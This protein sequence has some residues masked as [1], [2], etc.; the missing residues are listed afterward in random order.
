MRAGEL[1]PA[2]EGGP[3]I[4]AT[5][6]FARWVLACAVRFWP[7]ESRAWGAALAAEIDEATNGFDAMRWS[8]GG[9]MFFARSVISSAWTWLKSPAGSSLPSSSAGGTSGPSLKPRRSRIFTVAVLAVAAA[10]L[11]LPEGRVALQTVTASWLEFMPTHSERRTLDKL[12]A[13]AEKDHDAE[14][15]AFVALSPTRDPSHEEQQRAERL[16]E[17][18]VAL[19]PSFIWI[20]GAKN[21][22][23]SYYPAQKEWV[24]RLQAADPE[25]AVP[26]LLEAS[27]VADQK[28]NASPGHPNDS[29][30]Q[31]LGDDPQWMALMGRAYATPKYDSYLAKHIRLMQTVWNRNPNLPPHIFLMGLWSHAIPNLFLTRQY[32]DIELNRAKQ[33][34]AKGDT[35]QAEALTQGVATFGARMTASSSTMIEELIG[36]AISRMAYKEFAEIYMAEGKPEEARRATAHMDELEQLAR[37]RAGRDDA[38]RAERARTFERQAVLVQGSVILGGLALMCA[39]V[40]IFALE[41]W[42]GKPAAQI[43]L[44]RRVMCFAV[45]WAPVTLLAAS[46]A[47]LVSFLPFQKVLA[48]FRVS[49]F[50]ASDELRL[51]DAMW[52]LVGVPEHVLGMDAAVMFWSAVTYTLSA[53]VVC[54]VAWG[55]YRARRAQ[56]KPA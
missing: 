15:L 17:R 2:Y 41:V 28:L 31:S 23:A 33:A 9:M 29:D 1:M 54:M 55:V 25:N 10:L 7:E 32:A 49:S 36:V 27:A 18:T 40:G 50:Q 26:I 38:G 12:A 24:E 5:V 11:L 43:G 6:R 3:Q 20:Y 8:L 22:S 39:V 35:K 56:A 45:D 19:D 21:H 51:S 14:T 42:R 44:W 16:V 46:G 53:I 48:D 34:L 30:F 52:S 13:R 47:F 4:S 37:H